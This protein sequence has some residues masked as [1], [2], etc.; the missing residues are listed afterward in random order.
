MRTQNESSPENI[1]LLRS[2]FANQKRYW[3][4]KLSGEFPVTTFLFDFDYHNH[5]SFTPSD[6]TEITREKRKIKISFP[7]RLG[8]QMITLSK[9][10]D[11]SLYI[12]LLTALKVLIS[13]YT[14]N[15][16]IIVV[17]PI[18]QSAVTEETINRLV[19]IRDQVDSTL[20]FREMV[21]R[22]RQ[23]VLEAYE[24]QDYPFD[25]L[26]EFLF[27]SPAPAE[28]DQ[29]KT[30]IPHI[31]D[32]HCSLANL[33][34][35]LHED[36]DCKDIETR[37][38]FHF[39]R[40]A[41][42]VNGYVLYD[43]LT[44]KESEVLRVT[45]HLLNLLANALEDVNAKIPGIS[46][47]T[48]QEKQHLLVDLN[49]NRADFTRDK[50]IYHFIA[51][52]AEKSP[53]VVAIAFADAEITYRELDSDANHLAG[54]LRGKGVGEDQPVGI[55]LE[56]S[57]WMV[58][59][60]LAVWKAGGAYIPIDANFP[61]QRILE[62]LKDSGTHVLIT[63]SKYV[64]PH[65]QASFN[66][67]IV[68][69]EEQTAAAA[70]SASAVPVVSEL[71]DMNS[72][73]YII[74][75]SGSTGQPKGVM[76]HHLGMMNHIAAKIHD[77]QITKKSIIAQ[78][79]SHTFDI[80]VWQFFAA[81]TR[82]GK[83]VIYPNETVLEPDRFIPQV[84]NRQV[85][86]LELVPSYLAV[87]LEIVTVNL[88]NFPSLDY[89]VVTGEEIKPDLVNRWFEKYPGIKLVNAYG[90]TEASDDITHLVMN[91]P[92]GR[93][94]IPIG[95]PVQ[96]FNIYILDH[97][98]N[99]C[100]PGVKGEICVSGIGVGRGY[101][102]KPEQTAKSFCLRQPG[103]SRF[104]GTRGLAPLLLER[105]LEGTSKD[106]MQSCNHAS[107]RLSSHYSPQY[108][109]TPLPH[110]PIYRTGDLGRWL[111]DGTIDFFGRKDY[112]VKIRGF[113]IEL[114]EIETQL[115]THPAVKESAVVVNEKND[116]YICAFLVPG[117]EL[118]TAEL[119]DYLAQ[120]LP[121]YMVPDYF[122][123]LQRM[124][125]TPNGKIDRKAL[126]QMDITLTGQQEYTAPRTQVEETLAEL[127]ANLLGLEKETIGIH[128]NFFE[129]G[130]QS[131]KATIMAQRI[132]KIFNINIP[133]GEIFKTPTIGGIASLISVTDWL[134][135]QNIN[136][137]D[138]NQQ[139]SEEIVI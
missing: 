7:D 102:N 26:L 61:R 51:E 92:P 28:Q 3:S 29:N 84:I 117:R 104:E 31:S 13:R 62:I 120:R 128:Y 15:E 122:I 99:L 86:I 83:T 110:Y 113:R 1:L 43:T 96:N 114:G 63:E 116:R 93:P 134:K 101:L 25:K 48:E 69:T 119:R 107:M 89:L 91:Q 33:H 57:P 131:L 10:S 109:I 90:P 135:T 85:T 105:T 30:M 41:D 130:G 103:G 56:R 49:S 115:S 108:P 14:L 20:T 112:Q 118:E 67:V 50:T 111:S 54:Y 77:L 70:A 75:T 18:N 38:S 19:F 22:V 58:K 82:G 23:S 55:L 121:Y 64:P 73:S 97:H 124:P 59:S 24:N 138:V 5:L 44:C 106:H 12:L 32:I 129:L 60:I 6:S 36:G 76:V 132:Y 40:E 80:S 4:K 127:W 123:Q 42:Q 137:S 46:L 45:N 37:L 21:L 17:S 133:V 11:L 39:E 66:G 47:L 74:Y 78:N 100:P 34:V 94:R 52:Q 71:R 9:N 79:S 125:L 136:H 35:P 16:D 98:M 126:L 72:L 87:M 81:L 53:G 95:K 88:M 2:R 65:I 27:P 139:E 68:K 8:R